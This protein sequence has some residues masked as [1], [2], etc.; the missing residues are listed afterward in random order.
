MLDFWGVSEYAGPCRSFQKFKKEPDGRGKQIMAAF[1]GQALR[2]HEVQEAAPYRRYIVDFVCLEKRLVIEV[3][4][5]QHGEKEGQIKDNK[6]DQWLTKEGYRVLRFWN[7]DV[8]TNME[9]F[10]DMIRATVIPDSDDC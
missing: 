9:G 2:R 1:A 7:N 10:M 6:R 8:L 5:G 4:G 3:D